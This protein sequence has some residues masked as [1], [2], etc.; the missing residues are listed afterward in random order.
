M[1][2]YT[3]YLCNDRGRRLMQLDRI[4][5]LFAAKALNKTAEFG[6]SLHPP[7]NISTLRD[8]RYIERN[9]RKDWQ[10][11]IWR[12]GRGAPHLWQ[13]YFVLKWGH[14]QAE[15]SAKAFSI[16]G[17][18]VNH[19]LTR[20]IVAAYAESAQASMTDYADDMAKAIVTDS[21]ED[22][23]APVPEYGTRAWGSWLSSR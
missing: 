10:V 1:S 18:D 14:S 8:F 20:R 13:A 22:D 2:R 3:V 19:L 23:A 5:S 6:L 4:K 17:Y 11:Q 15:N 21:M 12:K 9:I 16:G 7:S